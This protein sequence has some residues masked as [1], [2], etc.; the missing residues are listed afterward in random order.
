MAVRLT[1]FWVLALWAR[2]I[3]VEKVRY[4]P[5]NYLFFPGQNSKLKQYYMIV[6]SASTKS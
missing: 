4:K 2:D 1:T 5:L 6:I 3:I